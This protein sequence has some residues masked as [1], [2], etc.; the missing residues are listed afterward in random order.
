[1]LQRVHVRIFVCMVGLSFFASTVSRAAD[2]SAHL[3]AKRTDSD[4]VPA[5]VI[6]LKPVHESA[7]NA[8]PPEHFTLTQK[9]KTFIP[10]LLVV[11]LGSSVAFPNTDPFF[12]NVF[13]LFDGRRFDLGL[14]EAGSTRSVVFSREGVSYIFCNIHSEMSAVVITLTTPFFSVADPNG[15]FQITGVPEGDYDLHLWIEGR[16]QN[17]LEKQPRRIHLA[18]GRLDLGEIDAGQPE[19]VPHRNKFGRPYD[20]DSHPIY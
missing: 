17:A 19:Q 14:Y 13:S 18:S 1:M 15:R 12:H 7:S 20:V 10:H 5:A 8:L 2:V 9:N 3:A 11:P 16:Q 6:W 4:T